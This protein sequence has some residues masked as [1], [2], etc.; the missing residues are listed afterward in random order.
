MVDTVNSQTSRLHVCRALDGDA[1]LASQFIFKK[2][3][4]SFGA[5]PPPPEIVFAAFEE[6]GEVVGTLAV[7]L[8]TADCPLPFEDMYSYDPARLP[9]ACLRQATVQFGC[10]GATNPIASP[11]L[12]FAA[13]DYALQKGKRYG[14]C[15]LKP[16]ACLRLREI[17]VKLYDVV[18]ALIPANVKQ[19][20]TPY[21]LT[22][23]VPEI[24]MVELPQVY[25]I[26]SLLV[27]EHISN[28][29]LTIALPKN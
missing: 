16:Y 9:F 10:W 20:Y 13:V 19:E 8:G 5:A 15:I 24:Y 4:N 22:P 1:L 6:T 27:S 2:F 28:G 3:F 23:P 25:H 11:A 26:A 12:I 14:W 7:D 29:T 21:F 18:S 17:G